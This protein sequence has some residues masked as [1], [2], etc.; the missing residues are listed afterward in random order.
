M[1]LNEWLDKE[2][3]R[4][5]K[6]AEFFCLTPSA[7]TQWRGEV[8]VPKNRMIEVRDFTGGEVTLEELVP[9]PRQDRA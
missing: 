4:N 8:G 5:K 9:A 3:G 7:V 1:T 6:L 2:V